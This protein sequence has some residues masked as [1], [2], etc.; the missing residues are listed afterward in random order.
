MQA[1]IK[2]VTVDLSQHTANDRGGGMAVGCEVWVESGRISIL[3]EP[4]VGSD[5][6]PTRLKT[7][8]T[9]CPEAGQ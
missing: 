3:Y 7:P 2:Q 1:I 5:A 8:V 4:E 6:A 9:A